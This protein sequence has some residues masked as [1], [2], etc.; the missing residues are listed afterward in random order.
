[1]IEVIGTILTIA[2]VCWSLGAFISN[3][4][5]LIDAEY[6][7]IRIWAVPIRKFHMGDFENVEVGVAVG[8]E[9]LA[10]TI[11]MPTIKERSVTLYQ[12][13][14]L[15]RRLKIEPRMIRRSLL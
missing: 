15:F 7:R 12:T 6:L 5:Y 4:N 8:G 11:H 14:R 1:M 3:I 10:N 13:S 9:N 2:V